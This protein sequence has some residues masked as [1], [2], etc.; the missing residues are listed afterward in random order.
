MTISAAQVKELRERTGAGMMECKKALTKTD[1]DIEKAIDALK[2]SGAAKAENKSGRI[3]AEG[4]ITVK[5]SADQ[6]TA[7][8]IEI[9]CETDFVARDVNFLGFVENVANV[10]LANNA[11]TVEALSALNVPSTSTT[12]EVAR[13]EL[14]VKIGEN[15]KIRRLALLRSETPIA[16]YQHG[17]KIGV[18]VQ[19]STDDVSLGKDIAMHIAAS[20]P[21]AIDAK[22]V[23]AALIDKEREIFIAQAENSG[24]P[25]EIVAKMIDGRIKKFLAEVSLTGQPFVKDPSQTVGQLLTTAKSSVVAFVRYEVGEGIEKVVENFAEVVMATMQ[26]AQ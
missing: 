25:P 19:L 18:V 8:I 12:V 15:V 23:P 14:I 9:N 7:V 26:G 5:T 11:D 20:K 22:D 16:S 4:V 2:V 24:K 17:Q 10:A 6:K 21:D 1:G 13:Q 3:A